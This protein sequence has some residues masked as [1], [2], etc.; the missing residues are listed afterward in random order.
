MKINVK[1]TPETISLLLGVMAGAYRTIS[2]AQAMLQTE[3]PPTKEQIED[4]LARDK[5]ARDASL[6]RLRDEKP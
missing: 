5:A 4:M 6:A 2:E 1:L 3:T